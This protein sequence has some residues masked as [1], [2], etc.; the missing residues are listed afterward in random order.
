ML[1]VWLLLAAP[2]KAAPLDY[3]RG[4]LEQARTI[5]AGNQ[6]HNEKLTAL[7]VLFGKFLDTDAMGR[8]AL[9]QHWSSFSRAQQKEFLALF[10]E[11]LERTYVQK[12]LLFENPDFLYAGGQLIR[13][14]AVVDTKIVTPRDEFDFKYRLIP[15]GQN[16]VVTAIMVESV[17]LTANLG[18]QLNDLLGRM[19]ADDLLTLMKRKY[20]N[21]SGEA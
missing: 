1:L 15:A 18:S 3:T 9:G 20:G 13:D 17:N 16:W 21:A 5:V 11:L 12:L 14:G 4:I 10:R 2:A 7:S 6:A 8:E 19:S